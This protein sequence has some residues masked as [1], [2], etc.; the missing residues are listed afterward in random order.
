MLGFEC[1]AFVER[2]RKVLHEDPPAPAFILLVASGMNGLVAREL[3]QIYPLQMVR[4]AAV[5]ASRKANAN[6]AG[7]IRRALEHPEWNLG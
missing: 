2:L 4:A 1:L 7:L 5:Y 6:P 3:S